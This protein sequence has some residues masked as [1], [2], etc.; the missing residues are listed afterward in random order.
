MESLQVEQFSVPGSWFPVLGSQFWVA[1]IS[2]QFRRWDEKNKG[3]LK[4]VVARLAGHPKPGRSDFCR[5]NA[6]CERK[7]TG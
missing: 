5:W 4:H 1:G 3:G 6:F 7:L 2:G